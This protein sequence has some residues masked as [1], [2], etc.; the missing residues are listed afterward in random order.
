MAL[1]LATDFTYGLL[2]LH[3]AYR[4]QLW[5][6]AGW[7]GSYLLWGAGGLHPSMARLEQPAPGRE[8]VLTRF[9]LGLL[10]CASLVAP[11]L[12][13]LHDLHGHDYDYLVVR[14]ASLSLFALVILRMAGLV[15]RQERLMERE[16]VL[17]EEVH[18]RRGEARFGALVR[19]A[20]DLITVVDPD[21][22][23]TFQSPS[24]ERILGFTAS[25]VLGR[26]FDRLVTEGDRL[27]LARA[28]GAAAA[29][30]AAQPLEC[31]LSPAGGSG[32]PFR[33]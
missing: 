10:T 15:S 6:D 9:R 12:G 8:V 17:S 7:I 19:H 26:R 1:L 33:I 24:I 18:R 4:G 14:V 30:E 5:L 31:S 16:R 22:T 23:V 2:M 11:V 32:R 20:S 25:D 27:P 13:V 3:G 29:G 28:V 21:T